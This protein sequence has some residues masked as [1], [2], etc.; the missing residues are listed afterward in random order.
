[1]TT[2]EIIL[3]V[4]IILAVVVALHKREKAKELSYKLDQSDRILQ[5]II[6]DNVQLKSKNKIYER[7]CLHDC[8]KWIIVELSDVSFLVCK[9]TPSDE[10]VVIA[11]TY[12]YKA[13]DADD[14]EYMKNCAEE[15][16]E[17]L[18]ESV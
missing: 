7:A 9:T 14:R 18:T 3:T 1:M 5:D 2:I 17:K 11:R 15:L 4:V 13:G 10:I 8:Y 16:L 12:K 6:H